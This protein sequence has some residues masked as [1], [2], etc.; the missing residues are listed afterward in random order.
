MGASQV[1]RVK[2]IVAWQVNCEYLEE[3]A[4]EIELSE[5]RNC[6]ALFLRENS[7]YGSLN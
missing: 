3:N 1:R 7:M 2:G 6:G 4:R 5:K